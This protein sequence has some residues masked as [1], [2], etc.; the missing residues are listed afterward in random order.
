MLPSNTLK[1]SGALRAGAL[2]AAF[3]L[4]LSG[5]GG[6]RTD[7]RKAEAEADTLSVEVHRLGFDP[8]TLSVFEGKVKRNEFFS[9]LLMRLGMDAQQAYNLSEACDS[10][11]DVRKF[12]SGNSFGAYYANTGS[13]AAEQ[14][15]SAP[16]GHVPEYIV[17]EKDAMTDL[18]LKCSEPYS[19]WFSERP[20]TV[21]RKYAEVT[22]SSSLWN[23]MLD[24]GVSPLLILQLSDIY[25]W[26]VDF[27]ALQKSRRYCQ[28]CGLHASGPGIPCNNVRPEGWRQYLLERQGREYA[29]A[30]PQGSSA[31][32]QDKFGILLCKAS[33]YHQKSPASYR[34][35]LCRSRRDS[36]PGPR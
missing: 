10:V 21:E 23:D 14:L 19:V 30:V 13:A 35:G 4:L 22:I 33:S 7:D 18:V 2:L 32:F 27:F 20:V 1:H 8:D 12:R 9:S 31:V 15:S 34:G 5:C 6:R 28:V 24:A 25:A 36:G 3:V 26:T 17:Y 11:F 29:Q 16:D